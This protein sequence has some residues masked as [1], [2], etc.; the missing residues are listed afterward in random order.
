[1]RNR[2]LAT[3]LIVAFFVS[4]G[5]LSGNSLRTTNSFEQITFRANGSPSPVPVYTISNPATGSLLGTK[6]VTMD[7]S[8]QFRPLTDPLGNKPSC[9]IQTGDDHV[10]GTI[11]FSVTTAGDY[12]FRVV[13]SVPAMV[14]GSD[15]DP[16]KYEEWNTHPSPTP[17]YE[18]G[19]AANMPPTGDLMLA[20]YTTAFDP[21][22]PDSNVLGCNDDSEKM[23]N[24]YGPLS[25]QGNLQ[26]I[27]YSSSNQ[28][29]NL[30]FP[31]FSVPN[32]GFGDYT[33]LLTTWS[34]RYSMSSWAAKSFGTQSATFEF[35]GPSGGINFTQNSEVANNAPAP[36]NA[37]ASVQPLLAKTGSNNSPLVLITLFFMLLGT[38]IF[39]AGYRGKA[40]ITFETNH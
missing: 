22:Q 20:L 35:W 15:S 6:V 23:L 8:R 4:V 7:G 16:Y 24:A 36:A 40:K 39:K 12:T 30:K 14:A 1:M 34:E 2:F 11:T 37:A 26:G 19:S 32:L 29:L 31:E 5:T 18:Y 17:S 13:D 10:Y 38:F 21:L 28:Y 3:V 33:I 25:S 9:T 27:I